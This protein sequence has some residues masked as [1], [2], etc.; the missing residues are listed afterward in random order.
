MAQIRDVVEPELESIF[1]G[2]KTAKEGLDAAV[3][4]ANEILKEFAAA[5]KP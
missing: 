2:N 4:K 1:A 5:N 3:A